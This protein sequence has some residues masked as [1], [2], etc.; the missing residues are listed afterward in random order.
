LAVKRREFIRLFAAT[1]FATPFG[2]HA[3]VLNK[4]PKRIA[5]LPDLVPITLDDWRADMR[6]LGWTEGPDFVV[7]P[8]GV[9]PETWVKLPMP[10]V[11]SRTDL[12]SSSP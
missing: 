3:Q 2:V 4:N 6:A 12:T 11:W 1:S 9:E 7:M 8:S 5:F 10:N